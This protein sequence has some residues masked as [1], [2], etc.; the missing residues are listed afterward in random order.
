VDFT[1]RA[2]HLRDLRRIGERAH[3]KGPGSFP[4]GPSIERKDR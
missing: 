1:R 2:L 4:P 3:E